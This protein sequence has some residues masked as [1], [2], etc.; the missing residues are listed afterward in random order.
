[1]VD[2]MSSPYETALQ[3]MISEREAILKSDQKGSKSKKGIERLQREI[4]LL[5][6]ELASYQRVVEIFR[7]KNDARQANTK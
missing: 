4:T 3:D 6:K 1:M 2:A 5:K 7:M